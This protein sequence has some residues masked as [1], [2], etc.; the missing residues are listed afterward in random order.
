MPKRWASELFLL[1]ALLALALLLGLSFGRPS[2]WLTGVLTLYVA[3]TLRKLYLLDRLLAEGTRA[4]V[5]DTRGLWAETFA[6]VD[7]LR[8]KAR[9]RKQ[10]YRRLLQEVRESTGALSDAAIILNAENEIQW[11][12]PAATDLLGL[13]PGRDIG[14]R[15]DNLLRHPDFVRYLEN[16]EG[17]PVS[18]PSPRDESIQLAVQLIPYAR[19]QSLAIFRDITQQVQ[20]ER[21]RRD[22]VANASHELRSPLTVITGYLDA[23]EEEGKLP[24]SWTAPILDMQRQAQRM[25]GILR[26]LM[27]LARLESAGSD[28]VRDFVDVPGMLALINKDFSVRKDAPT[29]SLRMETDAALLGDEAELHSIFHNLIHNAVR[30]TP[31]DGEVEITWRS[32]QQGAVLY[33]KD[34]G[35]GIPAELI[36]RITERFF[37]VDPGRSRES[38]G[39]GLGLAIVKHA[40]QRHQ[41]T[42]TIES[43]VGQGSAFRCHFPISR[44]A[45]RGDSDQT[46][47]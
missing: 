2:W 27:E 36:P 34:T 5:F 29:L 41:G 22:F 12:N 38:G 24:D 47:V 6:Q 42:L 33:V 23:L 43:Q 7:R 11:F 13:D 4:P 19:S 26:D 30:F 31:T 45:H 46:V 1:G 37:R 14:Q 9:L 8:A 17:E 20:L 28:A 44:L 32:E 35:I 3:S 25:T 16:H 21:T 39:T 15:I 18:I 10:R 40:L